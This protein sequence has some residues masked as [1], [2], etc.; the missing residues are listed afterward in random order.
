LKKHE[1][2][3]DYEKEM[4]ANPGC[5]GVCAGVQRCFSFGGWDFTCAELPAA[6]KLPLV[7]RLLLVSGW[8]NLAAHRHASYTLIF[9]TST[10]RL[11][12]HNGLH[13]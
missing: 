5:N 7:R 12:S 9:V 11:F 10:A 1:K 8:F 2:E 3:E 4:L 6:G 13:R